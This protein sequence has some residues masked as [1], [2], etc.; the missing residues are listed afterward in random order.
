MVC[1]PF[2][3]RFLMQPHW[4]SVASWA[5]DQ[6]HLTFL[7]APLAISFPFVLFLLHPLVSSPHSLIHVLLRMHPL[8]QPITA[9]WSQ[10][11]HL[12]GPDVT[13]SWPQCH[14]LLCPGFPIL[15][16]PILLLKSSQKSD[17]ERTQTSSGLESSLPSSLQ[18]QN[19]VAHR[20]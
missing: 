1:I 9:S 2:I 16:P 7:K 8:G 12:L 5:L 17:G 19:I 20:S 15:S 13:A 18:V 10:H 4:S 14:H 3:K 6:A 11:Y